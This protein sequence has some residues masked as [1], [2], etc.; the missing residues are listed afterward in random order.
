M[1]ALD[2]KLENIKHVFKMKIFITTL[3][4]RHYYP[5]FTNSESSGGVKI[6]IQFRQHPNATV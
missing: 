4:G 6:Q 2:F 5:Q 1:Q 3:H